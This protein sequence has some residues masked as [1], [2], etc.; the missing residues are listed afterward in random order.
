MY[1]LYKQTEAINLKNVL[2]I[3]KTLKFSYQKKPNQKSQ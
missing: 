2:T 1:C 3:L